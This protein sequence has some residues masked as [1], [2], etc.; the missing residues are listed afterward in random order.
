MLRNRQCYEN[1]SLYRMNADS[2]NPF[3]NR[4][5]YTP[6]AYIWY[7]N[8]YFVRQKVNL[9]SESILWN[10]TLYRCARLSFTAQLHYENAVHLWLRPCSLAAPSLGRGAVIFS[11]PSPLH[12]HMFFFHSYSSDSHNAF[13]YWTQQQ[14]KAN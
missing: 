14:Q 12:M 3:E 6:Y 13:I 10:I 7:I 4:E 11:G 8:V 9:I 1:F 2:P 5:P